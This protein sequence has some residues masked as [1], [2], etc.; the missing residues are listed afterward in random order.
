[1][2]RKSLRVFQL[3]TARQRQTSGASEET[4]VIVLIIGL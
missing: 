4:L 3:A 2:D 1:V